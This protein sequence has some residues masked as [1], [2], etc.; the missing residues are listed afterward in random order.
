MTIY[1]VTYV[2]S[3]YVTSAMRSSS[4][5]LSFNGWIFPY[6]SA[7]CCFSVFFCYVTVLF[8]RAAHMKQ[9]WAQKSKTKMKQQRP[10]CIK[11]IIQYLPFPRQSLIQVPSCPCLASKIRGVLSGRE[12]K[13]S[14]LFNCKICVNNIIKGRSC[15]SNKCTESMQYMIKKNNNNKNNKKSC[16]WTKITSSQ[17]WW[18]SNA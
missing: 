15:L 8:T 18:W 13:Y 4:I 7:D 1:M 9:I 14:E 12:R 3:V 11:T 16:M 2:I 17:R 10:W 6:Y 5:V